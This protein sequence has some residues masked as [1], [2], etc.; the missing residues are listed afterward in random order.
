MSSYY[1]RYRTVQNAINTNVLKYFTLPAPDVVRQ[2]STHVFN[3]VKDVKSCEISRRLL[4]LAHN[5][6]LCTKVKKGL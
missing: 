4:I 1:T 3:S 6:P 2:G 5:L